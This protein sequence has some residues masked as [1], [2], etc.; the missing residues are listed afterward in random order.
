MCEGPHICLNQMKSPGM[1]TS[2]WKHD[3]I[4]P[5]SPP[6]LSLPRLTFKQVILDE[7]AYILG[8][9]PHIPAQWEE[10]E[11]RG[12]SGR[13]DGGEKTEGRVEEEEGGLRIPP[14]FKSPLLPQTKSDNCTTVY[15]SRVTTP[16]RT[17]WG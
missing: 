17:C 2:G 7:G 6:W 10:E 16:S 15:H 3:F 4:Q 13:E 8:T 11:R 14:H 12:A 5:S 9:V 1:G